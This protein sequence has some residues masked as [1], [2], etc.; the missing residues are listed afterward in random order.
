MTVWKKE[1]GSADRGRKEKVE[2][3]QGSSESTAMIGGVW[4]V[5]KLSGNP[6]ISVYR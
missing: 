4:Q 6:S 3:G 5:L 2:S 1:G